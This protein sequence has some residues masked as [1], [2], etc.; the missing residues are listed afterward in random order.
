MTSG[1]RGG[2]LTYAL[3]RLQCRC[4]YAH[5][6]YCTSLRRRTRPDCLSTAQFTTFYYSTFDTNRTQ[7]QPLY[8]CCRIHA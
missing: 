1:K 3:S 7:L 8:V 2:V 4:E 5:C 6:L